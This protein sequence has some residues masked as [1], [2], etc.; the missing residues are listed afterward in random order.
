MWIA[1][2]TVITKVTVDV[3]LKELAHHAPQIGGIPLVKTHARVHIVSIVRDMMDVIL[4]MELA[5]VVIT[6]FIRLTALVSVYY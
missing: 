3:A 2:L 4:L 6:D 1:Q 5:A